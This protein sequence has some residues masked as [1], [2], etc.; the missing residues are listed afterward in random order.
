MAYKKKIDARTDNT[1]QLGGEKDG[2]KNPTT[3]EG[4]YLGSKSVDGDYGPGKLHIFNTSEGNIGVWGKTNLNHLL[5]PENV[6][7]M[8]LVTFTGMGKAKKGRRPAYEYSLQYD[9]ENTIDVTGVN[10]EATENNS[11]DDDSVDDVTYEGEQASEAYASRP[12]SGRG[13]LA[14]PNAEKQAALQARLASRKA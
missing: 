11:E 12:A 14:V 8:C 6:G 9:E 1:I 4:Y 7:Q 10:L 13:S 2:I 5:S 3:I